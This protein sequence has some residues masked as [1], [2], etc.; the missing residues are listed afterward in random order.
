MNEGEKPWSVCSKPAESGSNHIIA[1]PYANVIV[2]I[3]LKQDGI[4]NIVEGIGNSIDR[5]ISELVNTIDP[6]KTYEISI[7]D[8]RENISSVYTENVTWPI[9]LKIF[10]QDEDIPHNVENNLG[11]FSKIDGFWIFETDSRVNTDENYVEVDVNHLNVLSLALRGKTIYVDD[12]GGVDY[13]RIQDAI[14]HANSGDKIFVYEGVYNENIVIEKIIDLEGEYSGVFDPNG[15]TS[16]IDGGG[17]GNVITAYVDNVDIHGFVIQ[18]CGSFEEDAGV[19]IRSNN[20][21]IYGNIIS[22]NGA[23]G[24]YL[25]DS[26]NGNIIYGNDITNN[27]G[28]GIFIWDSSNNNLILN[29][30]LADNSW[31]N[32]KDKCDNIWDYGYPVGGNYWD[33]YNG[34][35]NYHGPYQNISGS[36]GIGD[37]PYEILDDTFNG[38]N[39]DSYPFISSYGWNKPPNSPIIDGITNGNPGINY[40]FTFYLTEH[41][42]QWFTTGIPQ[43]Y[44]Y[45]EWGDGTNSSW[46][47]PYISDNIVSLSHNWSE[48]GN[49]LIKVKTKDNYGSESN[50][51]SLEVS[52]PKNKSYINTPFARFLE[53]YPYMFPILRRLMEV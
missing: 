39:E 28:A 3:N 41:H 50:W 14:D 51:A 20:N 19:D 34:Q 12:D 31:F 47:G 23:T 27:D 16:I 22:N 13:T 29:N 10:Y 46:L 4:V 11:V 44:L 2:D 26:A 18:N 17:T 7:I 9:T 53:S 32:A 52:M 30:N 25:H 48:K 24:I 49:Y 33:D 21:T 8:I 15:K 38:G 35:D 5:P 43:I 42:Y 36:D 40:Q 45:V 37:I 6:I 1:I